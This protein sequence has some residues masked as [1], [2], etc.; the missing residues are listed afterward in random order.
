MIDILTQ[1]LE[2]MENVQY[3]YVQLNFLVIC[4]IDWKFEIFCTTVILAYH[5]YDTLCIIQF[6]IAARV[7][8]FA[9]GRIILSCRLK[10]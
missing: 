1:I 4:N 2:I 8:G 5:R 10:C 6:M 7:L 9:S 3:Y